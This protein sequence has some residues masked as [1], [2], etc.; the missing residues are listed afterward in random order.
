M[1]TLLSSK[2]QGD[3]IKLDGIDFYVVK[4]ES[5]G[6]KVIRKD[7]LNDQ[8]AYRL[9]KSKYYSLER[10]LGLFLNQTYFNTLSTNAK[11]MIVQNATWVTGP[12]DSETTVVSPVGL[13]TVNEWNQYSTRNGGKIPPN[14]SK[15]SWLLSSF[16]IYGS[17]DAKA[18][19]MFYDGTYQSAYV[20]SLQ[21][22]RPVLILKSDLRV[23][24]DGTVTDNE[25]P[26]A[27]VI[28]SQSTQPGNNKTV[29]LSLYFSD[30]DGDS[31][32]YTATSSNTG[33]G[34]ATISGPTLTLRPVGLG[35]TSITVTANDGKGG[36]KSTTFTFSVVNS[37]PTVTLTSPSANQTL[38]ENDAYNITGTVSDVDSGNSVTVRYQINANTVRAIKAFISDGSTAEAFSKTLTF[39]S[40]SLYDGDTLIAGNLSDGVAHTLKVWAT[41]DQ[42]G[43]SVIAERAFYAVPNRAPSLSINPIS[44]AGTI[45]NDKFTIS[46]SFSDPDGNQAT[47]RYRIN[48]SN[49]V[50]VASGVSGVF[51]FDVSFGQ[52]VIGT[53]NIVVEVQD[54][55][56]SK[57]SKTIKLSKNKIET[58][59]LRSTE[60]Y[61]I[62]PPTGST[63]GVLLWIHRDPNLDIDVAIS[64]GMV[65]E[66]ESYTPLAVA[67]SGPSPDFDGV[68]E[69][70]FYIE[71][72]TA[73][74]NIILQVDM[75]RSSVDVNDSIVLIQGVL[76]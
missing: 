37:T 21:Y 24:S 2:V 71:S 57:T 39:K 16:A 64:M 76:E 18:Y 3:L 75:T 72:D 62:V 17:T 52:L 49:S 34:T 6:T 65:G 13:F 61:K 54:S 28:P 22:V 59:L 27:S 9:D 60:R 14:P 20:D 12:T 26:I 33:V 4:H 73:K 41:D 66:A 8:V 58:P 25:A 44:T 11:N 51:D 69:D 32:T 47:V 36:T 68:I 45:D 50:Q 48:G 46:G 38:Y 63:R 1:T 19:T 40:G 43:T 42:G 35:S 5:Q 74:D 7:V 67:N 23:L 30:P 15:P 10:D 31:M 56:G 29:N 53:N 70:E 55:M